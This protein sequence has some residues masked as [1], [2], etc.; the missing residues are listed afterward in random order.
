MQIAQT[1]KM[2]ISSQ[3]LFFFC[4]ILSSLCSS[5]NNDGTGSN[6]AVEGDTLTANA[7]LLTLVEVAEDIIAATVRNPWD[8]GKVLGRFLLVDRGLPEEKIPCLKNFQVIRVPVESALVFSSVHT[9]PLEELGASNLIKGVADSRYFT[10][11]YIRSGI[12]DGSITD[13]GNSMSPS[14]EKIVSLSPQIALV[15]PYENSGHGILDK[16]GTVTIDMADYM[17]TTPLGRAEWIL[18]LGALTGR[19]EE[20][21]TQYGKIQ[22]QY[23]SLKDKVVNSSSRPQVLSEVPYSGVWYQPG[24][25]SYMSCL[26]RDA[27]GEPLL[28][29]DES[30]GSVQL[31]IAN[32]FELGEKAEVWLIKSVGDMTGEDIL[33]LTPLASGIKAFKDGNVWIADTSASTLYDDLAFHPE[34]ILKDFVIIFHPEMAENENP[35]TYF[36]K[37]AVR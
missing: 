12:E 29:D 13:V 27:G 5:C 2:K 14:L 24:G 11:D 26:I 33:S 31:D 25:K 30:S 36:K 28:N 6:A 8:S 16:T 17:E 34:K 1:K 20:A 32:A 22:E 19:L 21:K 15:S 37:L 9:A 35:T 3:K 4:L 18:L 23:K 10:S 7:T